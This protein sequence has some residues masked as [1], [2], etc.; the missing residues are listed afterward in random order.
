MS[1]LVS[2]IIPIYNVE[3]YLREC[4]DSILAQTYK[5]LEVILIDDGSTDSSGAIA[6][7][8]ASKDIRIH[9][10]YQ[11]NQGAGS[12]RN[13]GLEKANGEW[14]CF[15]D[16]D[17]FYPN[18]TTIATLCTKAEQ[19]NAL[20]CGGSFS[21]Y[22]DG[23]IHTH[24][25][26]DFFGYTFKKEGFIDYASYQFDFGWI[27]FLYRTSFLREHNLYQ[28]L[29]TKYEDPLFFVRVM[30]EAKRLY[31]LTEPTYLY[32]VGHQTKIHWSAKNW[33]DQAKSM[34]DILALAKTNNL[35]TLYN[36]TLKRIHKQ[37][38][39]ALTLCLAGKICID[40]C[41]E[42]AKLLD[43]NPAKTNTSFNIPH[44]NYE[45][46]FLTAIQQR[47]ME[48]DLQI[49]HCKLGRHITKILLLYNQFKTFRKK[50]KQKY[51]L[52]R[53]ENI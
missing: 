34:S 30:L 16:P 48:I 3:S 27:R 2:I 18:T 47:L 15:I 41:I 21:E 50:L 12:A 5:N 45:Q 28:P 9:Y 7:E 22:R 6:K 29:Y 33:H 23:R 36:L 11:E 53:K 35:D 24:Y 8:Y 4:L 25:T 39:E 13:K 51:K 19:N 38:Q 49:Y 14:V 40:Y 37:A 44:T 32:R 26:S 52:W 42:L 10:F 31:A 1:S 17:D 20:V 46:D 43:N